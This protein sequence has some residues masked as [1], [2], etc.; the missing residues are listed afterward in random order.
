MKFELSNRLPYCVVER[1]ILSK[2]N[3]PFIMRLEYAFH[4]EFDLYLIMEFVN[5]GELFFHLQK[6]RTK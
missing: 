6:Q 1:E 4:D 3:H 2:F 5:G